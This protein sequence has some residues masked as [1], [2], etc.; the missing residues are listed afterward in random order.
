M[1]SGLKRAVY[2]L[3]GLLVLSS[4][5]CIGY[6]SRDRWAPVLLPAAEKSAQGAA[7]DEH[8]HSGHDHAGH[9]LDD[10]AA[11]GRLTLS[12]QA[13]QNL[14][15]E[16]VDV[17]LSDFWRTIQIPGVVAE[18]PGHSE[19]RIPATLVGIVTKIHV[20]PG[21]TVKPG[22]P[23][24]DL[25]PTGDLLTAAQSALLKTLKDIELVEVELKRITPLVESGSLSAKTKIEKDYERTRL[26]SLQLVQAQELL[27]RGLSTEQVKKIVDTKTL[28]R[29]F[30]VRVPSVQ[31]IEE[32]LGKGKHDPET[33]VVPVAAK[34]P[35]QTEPTTD[36]QFYTVEKIEVFPG[37]L[38]QTGDELV[39]LAL[40]TTLSIDGMAFEREAPLI[41]R[42]MQEQWP[43]RA[44]FE[45]VDGQP[46]RRDDLKIRYL[47]NTVDGATRI[48]HFYLRLPNTELK[49]PASEDGLDFRIW[50]FKPGQFVRLFVPIE[51][52]P[53][54]IV[55]PAEAVV[56][57]GVEAYVFC[58]NGKRLER[59]VVSLEY[60]DSRQAVI[61]NDGS[62]TPGFDVVAKNQA[63]QLNLEL[64]KKSGE[65]GGGHSHEGHN[66]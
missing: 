13:R 47:D 66:H 54:R 62:L 4:F 44:E 11:S 5:V 23:L 41:R 27:V 24:V 2:E 45:T 10:E 43:I 8:G 59:T 28:I 64:K 50:T 40:H 48:Q 37:K 26:E 38:I 46:L 7:E 18:Q 52:L 35:E 51:H 9:H 17:E 34:V 56:K 3:S 1:K 57:D 39:G 65:G 42:A 60:L 12:E 31:S 20:F 30:T 32:P 19:R 58:T 14:G 6:F 15:L 36:N 49:S 63:Y 61:K 21:Q 53:N 55:L 25:Q 33:P 22:D 16:L 29:Q